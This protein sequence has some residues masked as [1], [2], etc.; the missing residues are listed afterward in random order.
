MT[1]TPGGRTFVKVRPP[2]STAAAAEDGAAGHGAASLVPLAAGR[3]VGNGAF[4]LVEEAEGPL[5]WRLD[6]RAMGLLASAAIAGRG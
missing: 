3:A 5:D 2:G 4:S 6:R 1:S